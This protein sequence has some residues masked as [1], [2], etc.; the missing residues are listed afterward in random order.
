MVS[1]ASRIG[2]KLL[3]A[4]LVGSLLWFGA[5]ECGEHRHTKESRLRAVRRVAASVTSR[6]ETT[7]EVVGSISELGPPSCVGASACLFDSADGLGQF[8]DFKL[9]SEGGTRFVCYSGQCAAIGIER[10]VGKFCAR[11][12]RIDSG[13]AN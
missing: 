8:S 9:L 3:V 10:C 11:V 12:E 13:E 6:E 2:K 7:G 4:F 5:W 1:R